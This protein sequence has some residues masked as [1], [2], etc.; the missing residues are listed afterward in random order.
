[1][2]AMVTA[3]DPVHK[4]SSNNSNARR[5]AVAVIFQ[6]GSTEF[7]SHL[8]DLKSEKKERKHAK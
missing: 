3:H 8:A 2:K 6:W 4:D 7:R 5:T 1:M